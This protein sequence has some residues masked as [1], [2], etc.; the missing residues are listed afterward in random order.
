MGRMSVSAGQGNPG[1]LTILHN[2][3]QSRQNP[4]SNSHGSLFMAFEIR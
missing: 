3:V 1:I 2:H 4:V